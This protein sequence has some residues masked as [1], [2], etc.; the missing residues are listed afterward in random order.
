MSAEPSFS[1]VMVTLALGIE[2]LY[3]WAATR[4]A[5]QTPRKTRIAIDMIPNRFIDTSQ[6]AQA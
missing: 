6:V 4:S 3:A 1:M 2:N 5:P